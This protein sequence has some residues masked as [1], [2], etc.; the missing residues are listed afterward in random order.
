MSDQRDIVD[1][2]KTLMLHCEKEGIGY[3]NDLKRAADEITRLREAL[4]E[5]HERCRQ[6]IA[7]KVSDDAQHVRTIA[8][9]S[10]RHTKELSA[11]SALK[12]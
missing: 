4:A 7:G 12:P 6:M 2:L 8:L 9:I 1:V 3:G 10:E 11:L 5:E